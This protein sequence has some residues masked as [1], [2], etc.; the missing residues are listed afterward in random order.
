MFSFSLFFVSPSVLKVILVPSSLQ[1]G[2]PGLC[3]Q[4]VIALFFFGLLFFSFK[5]NYIAASENKR[6]II[7]SVF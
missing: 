7:L 2:M 6:P 1:I 4:C 3:H 5:E